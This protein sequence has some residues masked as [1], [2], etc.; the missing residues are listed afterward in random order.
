MRDFG[1]KVVEDTDLL[2]VE[3]S[4]PTG[5]RLTHE[6]AEALSVMLWCQAQD[7]RRLL[8]VKHLEQAKREA[9]QKR[10]AKSSSLRARQ[11]K[12]SRAR[13]AS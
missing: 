1:C 11:P 9:A 8:P 5:G 6:E 13:K 12:K 10:I 3:V 4:I 2:F 7:I